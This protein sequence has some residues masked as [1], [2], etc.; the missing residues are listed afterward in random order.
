MIRYP[1]SHWNKERNDHRAVLV[2]QHETLAIKVP[3]EHGAFLDQES[4]E[5]VHT[6]VSIICA[7]IGLRDSGPLSGTSPDN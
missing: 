7:R 4:L 2:S 3:R 1:L 5:T 6:W